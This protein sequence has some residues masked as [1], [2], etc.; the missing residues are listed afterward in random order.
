MRDVHSGHR[1]L[2]RF[3]AIEAD[4]GQGLRSLSAKPC[5]K[6][7]AALVVVC[8]VTA[9]SLAYILHGGSI[10]VTE[11]GTTISKVVAPNGTAATSSLCQ[12]EDDLKVNC[13]RRGITQ[14][15]CQANGCCFA[16]SRIPGIPWCFVTKVKMDKECTVP[17][18]DKVNC[19]FRGIG[20]EN[21]VARGCC[22]ANAGAQR[23]PWCFQKPGAERPEPP[24]ALREEC[25]VPVAEKVE[26]GFPGITEPQCLNKGCCY[27]HTGLLG[28]P[29]CYQKWHLVTGTEAEEAEECGAREADRL[30]CGYDGISPI[31]CRR[32]GCCYERTGRPDVPFCFH[33]TKR[34]FRPGDLVV[35]EQCTVP[36]EERFDCGFKGMKADECRARGCCYA[37]AEKTGAPYC[38]YKVP[39]EAGPPIRRPNR[40]DLGRRAIESP[41]SVLVSSILAFLGLAIC[42][43][44]CVVFARF[45]RCN[46]E[47]AAL[48]RCTRLDSSDQRYCDIQDNFLAKW[49]TTMWPTCRVA[50]PAPRIKDIYEI[51]NEA[52]Q[53]VYEA[54]Q[55]E[56]EDEGVQPEA[57]AGVGNEQQCFFGARK[58]CDFGGALCTDGA[59]TVCRIIQ[60]GHFGAGAIRDAPSVDDFSAESYVGGIRFAAWAHTAK[61]QGL[62][63]GKRPPPT[64]TQD[65][66][67]SGAGNALFVAD[68]LVGQPEVVSKPVAGALQAGAH[69]RVA[70]ASTGIDEVVIF[71]EAQA[72]PRALIVFED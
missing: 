46:G 1:S 21:C 52:H 64:D 20:R 45:T 60:S 56:L 17:R 72:V 44:A 55:L 29:D 53:C 54:K 63:P 51:E 22:Y 39:T 67:C 10:K 8:I 24:K 27:R 12:I 32:Q 2:V 35:E 71:D 3:T 7:V 61:G 42:L 19:G 6:Y 25:T 57:D 62:A 49:N 37:T 41:T 33:N 70:D 68:V 15:E 34:T 28:E 4:D 13:G 36:D 40:T 5:I 31:Q 47:G 30:E 66:V 11:R 16:P 18:Q 69:S 48:T 59:C 65:F 26:C 9:G 43:G 23:V 58:R 38:F 14:P 50:V